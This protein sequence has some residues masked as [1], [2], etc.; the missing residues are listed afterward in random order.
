MVGQQTTKPTGQ[1]QLSIDEAFLL[2]EENFNAGRYSETDK[3]CIDIIQKEPDHIGAI[4]LLGLIAQK[5]NSH[6]LAVKLFQQA[7]NIDKS[8]AYL[9]YNLS[10]SLKKLGQLLKA[11]DLLLIAHELEPANNQVSSLL[12]DINNSLN[13][14]AKLQNPQQKVAELLQQGVAFY[15]SGELDRAIEHY[16]KSLEI[17]PDNVSALSC[18]GAALQAKGEMDLAVD[19]YQ[20]AIAIKP[21][22]SEAYYNLGTAKK[23]QGKLDEAVDCYKKAIAINPNYAGAYSNLGIIFHNQGR[24]VEAVGYYEKAFAINPDY[25]LAYSNLGNTLIMLGDN[26]LAVKYCQKAINIKPDFAQAYCNLGNGFQALGLVDKAIASYKKA[27]ELNPAFIDAQSNLLLSSQYLTGQTKQNLLKI[28]KEWADTLLANLSTQIFNHNNDTSKNRKLKIGFVSGDLLQHPVG[29]FMLGFFKHHPKNEL[30]ITCYANNKPDNISLLLQ[31]YIKGWVSILNMDDIQVA[32]RIYDDGIDILVDLSGHTAHNRLPVFVAKPAPVQISWAGYVST[33]GLPTIDWLI[34]DSHSITKNEESY[35]T[36]NI[37][38]LPDSW[39]CYTPPTY[40]PDIAKKHSDRI[41][42]GNFGNTAK[43]NEEI[44][45][46]WSKI[47][48]QCPNTDLLLIYRGMDSPSNI[49]RIT[50]HFS[51]AGI[52]SDR[53]FIEGSK[54]HEQILSRYNSITLALDTQPYSGGLTTLEALWMGVPVVT[55]RGE[56]FA[57]RH[58]TSFFSSLGLEKLITNSLNEY[59][60][61]AVDLISNPDKL[62]SIRAGLRE[63]VANSPLCNHK[64]FSNNVTRALREVW[65]KWCNEKVVV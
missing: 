46:V 34:G 39:L 20:M 56:T 26:D 44:L 65:V 10:V 37:I 21:D 23:E 36:E 43:I 51:S 61:L 29:Y 64:Q 25:A 49:K 12:A 9:F 13:L 31:S 58:S 27:F 41:L 33:T 1:S 3:L 22:Y 7:I 63:R 8:K 32:K 16:K 17:Q 4:N 55:T 11:K 42:L 5:I 59:V 60:E 2:A 19:S 40:A 48:L 18:L 62:N 6:K 47:M 54:P 57:S 28:H 50:D 52:N 45:Q 30:E 35:Y 38:R 24:F 14:T 15:Q 53:I